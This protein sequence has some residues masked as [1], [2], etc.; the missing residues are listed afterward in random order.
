MV[1]SIEPYLADK[2]EHTTPYKSY[3]KC[4]Y[5]YIQN[6][7]ESKLIYNHIVLL[8]HHTHTAYTQGKIGRRQNLKSLEVLFVVA[9]F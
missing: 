9:S 2:G 4:V 6:L 1:I 3:K 5:I 7:K 8:T